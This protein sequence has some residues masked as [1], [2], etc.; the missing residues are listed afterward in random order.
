MDRF[1][2]DRA[3]GVRVSESGPRNELHATVSSLTKRTVAVAAAVD[4][5]RGVL[6]ENDEG[7][8]AASRRMR[9]VA[10]VRRGGAAREL[11]P[12]DHDGKR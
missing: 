8:V 1:N 4:S 2:V 12:D 11:S 6:A 9:C 7:E 5:Y 10:G 3:R